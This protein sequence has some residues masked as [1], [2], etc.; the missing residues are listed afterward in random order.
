M[1]RRE[2]VLSDDVRGNDIIKIE[3]FSGVVRLGKVKVSL[4]DIKE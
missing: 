4:N 2:I 1:A 3:V